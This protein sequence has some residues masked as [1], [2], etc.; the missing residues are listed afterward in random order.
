MADAVSSLS[1]RGP[2]MTAFQ[3][4]DCGRKEAHLSRKRSIFERLI[5]PFFLLHPVRCAN[6]FRRQYVPVFWEISA[7]RHPDPPQPP[8]QMAA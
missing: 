3:C 2:G 5:L 4:R 7:R 1:A 6:C 8:R